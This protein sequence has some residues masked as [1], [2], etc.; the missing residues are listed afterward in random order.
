MNENRLLISCDYSGGSIN[1][2]I[3]QLFCHFLSSRE[4]WQLSVPI[5]AT[6]GNYKMCIRLC[7]AWKTTAT[8]CVCFDT[9]VVL[10]DWEARDSAEQVQF[11]S[12]LNWILSKYR[13][14]LFK[15]RRRNEKRTLCWEK[16][17]RRTVKWLSGR[18]DGTSTS[19][20]S[21]PCSCTCLRSSWRRWLS[22]SF[23]CAARAWSITIIRPPFV[24]TWRI[25]RIS[26]KKFRLVGPLTVRAFR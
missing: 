13:N 18:C 3:G 17:S 6:L 20:S 12:L 15:Y 1:I 14:I 5:C 9:K 19:P 25:I 4:L 8:N 22:R 26:R 7:V 21:R 23:S 10:G 16:C 11:C 24:R 2:F